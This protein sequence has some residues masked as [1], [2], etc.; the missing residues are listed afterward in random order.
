L[1]W[2]QGSQGPYRPGRGSSAP[3]VYIW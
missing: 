3:G 2:C 1:A